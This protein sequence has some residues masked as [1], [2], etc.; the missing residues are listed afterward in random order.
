MDLRKCARARAC[1]CVC[2]RTFVCVRAFAC[3]CACVSVSVEGGEG[4]ER[5]GALR[6]GRRDRNRERGWM[7]GGRKGQEMRRDW[8]QERESGEGP[9]VAG[10]GR[11]HCEWRM[12]SA[13]KSAR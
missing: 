6:R 7:R 8:M 1:A 10:R 5:V 9:R 3:K 4:M 12:Q 11:W 13:A 2:V